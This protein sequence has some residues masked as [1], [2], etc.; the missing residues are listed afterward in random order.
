VVDGGTGLLVPPRDAEALA[1]AI[2]R[3]LDDG[4]LASRL[5][6]EARARVRACY[7]IEQMVSGTLELYGSLQ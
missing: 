5:A 4:A 6:R 3:L 1:A 7:S 2:L